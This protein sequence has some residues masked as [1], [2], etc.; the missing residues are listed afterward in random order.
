MQAPQLRHS[1]QESSIV[2]YTVLCKQYASYSDLTIAQQSC[3][4]KRPTSLSGTRR[5]RGA[6]WLPGAALVICVKLR[7]SLLLSQSVDLRL[8]RLMLLALSSC[9]V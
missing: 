2:A 3:V 9:C 7:S 1:A 6:R 8:C 4:K 5:H